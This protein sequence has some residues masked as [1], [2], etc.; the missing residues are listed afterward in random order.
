M[1]DHSEAHGDGHGHAHEDH[2]SHYIKIWGVLVGL[3]FVSV[4]GPA[5]AEFMPEGTARLVLV[6]TTA[7]GIAFVKAYLVM[8]EFMHLNVEK[9]IV[10]W[11]LATAL[12]F[13]VLLFAGVAPD[14]MRHEGANWERIQT[15]DPG[16]AKLNAHH[17]GGHGDGHG[18][19]HG[20]EH[21]GEHG[22]DHGKKT[23]D[24]GDGGNH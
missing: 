14:V 6:L 17:G 19:S 5:L 3:L 12:V 1:S 4:A 9:P 8:K 2:S 15:V 21:G 10:H 24:H 23:E 16:I 22:D 18:E 7:F 13:M 20:G 11:F